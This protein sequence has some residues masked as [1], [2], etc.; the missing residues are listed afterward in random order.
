M[1]L[2]GIIGKAARKAVETAQSRVDIVPAQTSHEV[3]DESYGDNDSKYKIS[4]RLNDAFKEAK[5]HAGEVEMLNTYAPAKEYGEE[6]AL[7]YVAIMCD[8]SVYT[9]VEEFKEKGIV[10]KAIELTP[11]SGRFYFKAKIEYYGD[12]MYFYGLDR[13]GGFWEN[14]GLCMIYPKAYMGTENEAKLMKI[15]DEAAESYQEEKIA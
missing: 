8:D 10:E 1:G 13:C 2:S 12:I 7:P 4:F 3:E 14:N 5:S 11:L 15:L 6:G 9:A